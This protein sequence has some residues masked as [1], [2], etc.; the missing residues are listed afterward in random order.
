MQS[1][2]GTREVEPALEKDPVEDRL[3][4][5]AILKSVT[6]GIAGAGKAGVPVPEAVGFG[7][8]A[9]VRRALE[10]GGNLGVGTKAIVMGVIRG[11]GER[12][13]AALRTLSHAARA[14]IGQT[15]ALSGDLRAAT[16]GLVL[17]A[18][19]SADHMGVTPSKAAVA[20]RGAAIDEAERLGPGAAIEVRGAFK[21]A[22]GAVQVDVP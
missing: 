5:G 16:R 9:A 6:D 12:E 8:R 10:V 7:V 17:G 18:L 1:R 13:A 21:T 11:T 3:P 14:V 15:A 22:L 2:Q 4:F 19:A 20:A